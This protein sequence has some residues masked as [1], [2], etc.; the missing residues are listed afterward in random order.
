MYNTPREIPVIFDNGSSYYFHLKIK[1]LAEEFKG[2][3]K[4]LSENKER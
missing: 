2:D 4:C 3:F 1:G